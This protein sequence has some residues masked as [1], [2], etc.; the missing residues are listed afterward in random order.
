MR[1]IENLFDEPAMT[2]S[3][4]DNNQF[5]LDLQHASFDWTKAPW[6]IR[7]ETGSQRL[8]PTRKHR[9]HTNQ[10]HRVHTNQTPLRVQKSVRA[11]NPGGI[12][13]V[14]PGEK[15]AWTPVAAALAVVIYA[16]RFAVKSLWLCLSSALLALLGLHLANLDAK[17]DDGRE[18]E[19]DRDG[20]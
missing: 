6:R 5:R 12:C 1:R 20:R 7:A 18:E 19:D 4:V 11:R 2:Q 10:T 17:P 3:L 13:D 9:V 16:L 14:E 8:S 15:C